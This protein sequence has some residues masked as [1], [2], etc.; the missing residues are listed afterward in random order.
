M[1]AFR[2][3]LSDW[4]E[5]PKVR[6]SILTVIILNAIILGME[7][8]ATIMAEAGGL[9][10][11]LDQI[12]LTIFLIELAVKLFANGW[13]FFTRFWNVFDFF[14]IGIALLPA[15]QGMAVLRAMRILR[16]IR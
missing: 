9:L 8:S 2:A 10:K 5:T 12:C 7:T 4:L 3:R 15:T 6:Y 11:T 14:I 16:V 13:R 1:T